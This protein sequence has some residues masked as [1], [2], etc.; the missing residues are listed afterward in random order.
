MNSTRLFFTSMVTAVLI[1]TAPLSQAATYQWQ[2]ITEDTPIVLSKSTPRID[3]NFTCDSS[4][5]SCTCTDTV[6]CFKLGDSKLCKDGTLKKDETF[7]NVYT[8]E[9]KY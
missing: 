3:T 8:C 7:P 5:H 9:F 4:T 6:D 1:H 2:P